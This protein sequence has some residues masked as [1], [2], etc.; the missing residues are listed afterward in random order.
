[1]SMTAVLSEVE[2][3][4][5]LDTE[6]YT[7]LPDAGDTVEGVFINLNKNLPAVPAVCGDTLRLRV[8]LSGVD[9]GAID[10]LGPGEP[11]VP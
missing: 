7:A 5:V 11:T 8:T 2:L 3:N 9:G 1:M 6:T 10:E 4:Q